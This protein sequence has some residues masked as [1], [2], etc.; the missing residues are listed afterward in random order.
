[1]KKK[2]M[3]MKKSTKLQYE[4]HIKKIINNH[5]PHIV[6][7]ANKIST[8]ISDFQNRVNV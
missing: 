6:N 4:K 3:K 1:M 2:N 8:L 7:E 5:I